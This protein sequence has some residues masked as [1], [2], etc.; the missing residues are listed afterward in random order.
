M[1]HCTH[2]NPARFYDRNTLYDRKNSYFG[3]KTTTSLS[4]L[5]VSVKLNLPRFAGQC[6]C[7]LVSEYILCRAKDTTGLKSRLSRP[8]RRP[9]PFS[10]ETAKE[11]DR[12]SVSALSV[13]AQ[14]LRDLIAAS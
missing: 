8:D 4:V 9:F 2:T 12:R 5:T 1:T 7:L 10:V 11:R 13:G 6:I 3:H 14:C